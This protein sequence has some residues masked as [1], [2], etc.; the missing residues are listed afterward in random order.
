METENQPK[1]GEGNQ[2]PKFDEAQQAFIQELI[3]KRFG[4]V[5]SKHEQEI[6]TLKSQFEQEKQTLLDELNKLKE[7]KGNEGKGKGGSNNDADKEQYTKLL[8][9]EK[10]NTAQALQMKKDLEERLKQ[11]EERN[12]GILKDQAIRD[13]ATSNQNYEFVDLKA[14]RKLTEDSIFWDED[15][16]SWVIKENGVIKKNSSLLPMTL[17]EF[18]AE[19]ASQHPYLVK[20]TTKAGAGSGEGGRSNNSGMGKVTAKADLKTVKDKVDFIN[21][22]G[23]EA[24]EKLPLKN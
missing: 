17:A 16:E 15:S 20:G 1:P 5:S 13:A 6:A 10:Q 7:G 21:K 11:A 9:A 19:F 2:P 8:D 4:K 12:R 3:D 22:F 23:Q 14:V 24:Y 18:Y